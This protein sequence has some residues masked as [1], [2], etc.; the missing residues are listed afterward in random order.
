MPRRPDP[1]KSTRA[2]DRLG[3]DETARLLPQLLGLHPELR[4]EAEAL[5]LRM[6]TAV[7]PEDVA[8]AMEFAFSGIAQEEGGNSGGGAFCEAA[9]A[10]F[11]KGLERLLAM[12]QAEPALAQAKG[13]ILGLHDLK[14]QL[15]PDA[16][17]YCSG[18]GLREVLEAWVR[19]RPAAA[20]APLLA[21]VGEVLP[22]WRGDVAPTLARLRQPA[23]RP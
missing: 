15:P 5:A 10:P 22:D 11:L 12:A 23:G 2:L 9:L 20:D 21:W 1:R 19:G 7:D 14:R 16:E 18:R 17:D 6:I 8:E 13:M 4:E 3:P